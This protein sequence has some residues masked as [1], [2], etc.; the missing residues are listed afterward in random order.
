[1]VAAALVEAVAGGAGEPTRPDWPAA[2]ALAAGGWASMTRL[3]RGD[4]AMS[5][6]I[7]ATNGPAI[8]TRLRELRR[9]I[10]RWLRELDRAD[11]DAERLADWFGAVRERL[12]TETP[13]GGP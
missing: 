8:A 6:G 9:T 2:A 13:E 12:D 4:A 3:A 11:P 10:D 1:V 7:A 5:A